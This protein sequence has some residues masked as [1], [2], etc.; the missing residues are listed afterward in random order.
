[1]QHLF[2]CTAYYA[3][4][5]KYIYIFNYINI[6]FMYQPSPF[7]SLKKDHLLVHHTKIHV[8]AGKL[9]FCMQH[10]WNASGGM[11]IFSASFTFRFFAYV[12]NARQ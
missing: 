12:K 6:V 1:M 9:G 2:Y 10:H 5:L 7:Y 11:G 3:V 8:E 4:L